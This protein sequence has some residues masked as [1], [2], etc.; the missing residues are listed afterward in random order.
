MNMQ[1]KRD[2]YEG[3]FLQSFPTL[4]VL[5]ILQRIHMACNS[6]GIEHSTFQNNDLT[7]APFR[8]TDCVI[9]FY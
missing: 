6:S 4:E 8:Q 1:S 7:I 2:S 9:T 3:D 5:Q